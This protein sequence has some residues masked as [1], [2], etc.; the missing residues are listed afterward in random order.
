MVAAASTSAADE[1]LTIDNVPAGEYTL[2]VQAWAVANAAPETT[3]GIRVFQVP[4]ADAGN[5]VFDPA[6]V[7]VQTGVPVTLTGTLATDGTTPYFG[8][9]RFSDGTSEVGSTLVSVG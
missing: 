3:F 1:V 5:L 6:T 7:P 9:V 2:H 4:D 8:R